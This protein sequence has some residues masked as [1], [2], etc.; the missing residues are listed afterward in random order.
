MHQP[1]Q[2]A[3]YSSDWMEHSAVSV[4]NVTAL[5]VV[6]LLF[7][8]G[9]ALWKR[10][11]RAMKLG[12]LPGRTFQLRTRRSVHDIRKEL[13]EAYF[14]RA[15]RMKYSTFKRLASEL[16]KYIEDATTHLDRP[17][18][19]RFHQTST[20]HVSFD[21]WLY[22]VLVTLPDTMNSFFWD[23]VDSINRQTPNVWNIIPSWSACHSGIYCPAGLCKCECSK[24]WMLLVPLMAYSDG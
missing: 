21:G 12:S 15:Y 8:R 4:A 19:D 6:A 11:Q 14:G 10:M 1:R 16:R 3:S 2:L 9:R 20:L 24:L 13:G 22:M 18:T 23:V 17:Q 5:V 7:V